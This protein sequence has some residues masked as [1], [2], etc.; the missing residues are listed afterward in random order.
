MNVSPVECPFCGRQTP[1]VSPPGHD[2][3]YTDCCVCG[4]AAVIE[5]QTITEEKV[6]TKPYHKWWN[7]G[8]G[9]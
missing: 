6:P 1:L 3:S 5:G 7:W 2:A 4:R 8:K 9:R